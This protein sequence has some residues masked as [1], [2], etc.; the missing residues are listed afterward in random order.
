MKLA[1]HDQLHIAVGDAYYFEGALEIL[2][3]VTPKWTPEQSKS[4]SSA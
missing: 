4:V 1:P 3:C 2:Y